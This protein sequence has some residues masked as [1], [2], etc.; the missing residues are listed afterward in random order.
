MKEGSLDEILK[1][2]LINFKDD[3]GYFKKLSMDIC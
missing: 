2:D 1:S 3:I